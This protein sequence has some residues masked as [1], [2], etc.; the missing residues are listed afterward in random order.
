MSLFTFSIIKIIAE[1]YM[2]DTLYHLRWKSTHLQDYVGALLIDRLGPDGLE[3]CR[4]LQRLS[5]QALL[6]SNQ[7]ESHQA[8]HQSILL[9]W[10]VRCPVFDY[11][12]YWIKIWCGICRVYST[13]LEKH[14]RLA[15]NFA[16][17]ADQGI[18]EGVGFAT[19]SGGDTW[20]ERA[21][22]HHE[23]HQ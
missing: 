3:K 19:E 2:K 13:S 11:S 1:Q 12:P 20:T 18:I 10:Y 9:L 5:Y 8:P 6:P 15:R 4:S 14:S 16:Y 7:E 22:G 21:V 17:A 23:Q